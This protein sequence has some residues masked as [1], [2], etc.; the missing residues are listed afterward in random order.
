MTVLVIIAVMTSVAVAS[1]GGWGNAASAAS[2]ARAIQFAAMRARAATLADGAERRLSCTATAHA[3]SCRLER[4]CK[5]G[6]NPDLST[7]GAW[8]DD[9]QLVVAGSRA[10]LWSISDATDRSVDGSTTTPWLGTHAVVFRPDGT[11]DAATFYVADR[12]GANA[13]NHYKIY[14]YA[15]TGMARL[16]NRW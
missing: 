12:G 4:A 14:V 1:L 5:K 9:G 15:G 11:A 13:A 6:V 8:L 2:L 10:M 16:V 3:S 7:C